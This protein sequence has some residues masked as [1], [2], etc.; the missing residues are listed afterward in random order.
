MLAFK[1]DQQNDVFDPCMLRGATSRDGTRRAFSSPPRVFI[2][3][4]RH[5]SPQRK[6]ILRENS[7]F[8]Y[9]HDFKK[10]AL[11]CFTSGLLNWR[12]GT[13]VKIANNV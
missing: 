5:T 12:Y 6:Q 13:S 8:I 11:N 2:M 3:Y 7:D 9:T 10:S 1:I 4:F